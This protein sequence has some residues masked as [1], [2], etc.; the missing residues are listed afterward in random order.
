MIHLSGPGA[1]CSQ[2]NTTLPQFTSYTYKT[3]MCMLCLY[4]RC[5]EANFYQKKRSKVRNVKILTVS[6]NDV[7]TLIYRVKT[8]RFTK[9][10]WN[11]NLNHVKNKVNIFLLIIMAQNV[12]IF[13]YYLIILYLPSLLFFIN[14]D[15]SSILSLPGRHGLNNM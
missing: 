1:V 7:K 4:V 3:C 9:S 5:M 14:P 2:S 15:F 12:T 8:I 10:K 6:Q 11:F 13:I